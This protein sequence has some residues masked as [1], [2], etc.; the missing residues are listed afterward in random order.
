M[1]SR[2]IYLFIYLVSGTSRPSFGSAGGTC[3]ILSG[4][5]FWTSSGVVGKLVANDRVAKL[6]ASCPFTGDSCIQTQ[7]S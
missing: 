5:I 7:V 4:C 3:I 6:A 2:A 1:L